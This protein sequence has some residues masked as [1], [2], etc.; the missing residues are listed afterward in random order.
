MTSIDGAEGPFYANARA[1]GDLPTVCGPAT[2]SQSLL[3]AAPR[4][5]IVLTES[6]K[7]VDTLGIA[8]STLTGIRSV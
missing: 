4:D 6:R 2:H 1:D 5:P 8:A 7:A 3:T